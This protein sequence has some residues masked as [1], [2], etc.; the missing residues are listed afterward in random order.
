MSDRPRLDHG[1]RPPRLVPLGEALAAN[2]AVVM[3]DVTLG[4][5]VSIWYGAVVRGDC[6]AITIGRLTNVQDTA[7]L[8]ADTGVPLT[9][10]EEVT[11]GHAAVVHGSEVGDRCLIGIGATV[12]GRSVIGAECII[13]AGAVVKE[14][15]VI[16]PRSLVAGVPGKVRRQVSDDELAG[17]HH[18]A[19][20]Y[21]DLAQEHRGDA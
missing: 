7:V 5:Q 3:G 6:A 9:I 20:T 8:H 4:A 11:I 21:W 17:F 13:A 14:G 2:T 18:H 1:P 19:R 10:G 15:D 16:P 12:L